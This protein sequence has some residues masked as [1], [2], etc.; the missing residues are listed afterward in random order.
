MGP[1]FLLLA[2]VALALAL[3]AGLN[4]LRWLQRPFPGF[5]LWGNLFV[6]AVGDTDWTGHRAGVPYQ[7]RLVAVDGA[8]VASATQVYRRAASVPVG[9]RIAYR[10]ATD[11]GERVVDIPTMRLSVPEY[12]WTFGNYL[13]LGTL[14]TLLGLVVSRIR[15]EAPAARALLA[16]AGTWGFYFI[17]AADIFGPGWFRPLCLLLQATAPVA[18]LHLALAFPVP[19]TVV[20]R[21]P[22]LLPVLYGCGVALGVVHNLVFHRWFGAMVAINQLT[23]LAMG[24]AG[25]VLIASLVH[26]FLYPPSA[27]VRQRTK[28]AVVGG[29]LAFV[30]PVF[31]V[32]FFSLT[33]VSFPINLVTLPLALFPLAIGYAIV[34]DDL[35]EVDAIIRRT[36]AWAILTGVIAAVYLGGVGTL[37]LVLTRPGGRVAQVMF[38]LAIVALVNPLRDRV[39]A[40]VDF[41]FARDRYDYRATVTEASQALATLLDLEA[42]VGRILRTITQGIHVDVGAVWLREAEHRYQL[43]AV[44]GARGRDGV[45]ALLDGTSALVARLERRPHEVV[46][47]GDG[48]RAPARELAQLGMTL[49]VPMALEHRLVGFLALGAK[50]SGR[51]YSGEDVQLVR[52]LANQGAVAAENAR[53][54]RA[55]VHANEEL[56]AAQS[57]LIEAE[58]LAAIGELSAA[59]AHGIRN[60]VAGIRAAAQVA[61]LDLPAD[62]PLRENLADIMLEA[63]KLEARIRGLLDFAKPFEPRPAPCQLD[64]LVAGALASLR[65]QIT[66]QAIVLE[67]AFDATLP[68]VPVDAVQIEQVVLALVS[69]A[70]EAMPEGGTLAVRGALTADGQRVRLEVADTGPGIPPDQL[71]RLFKLFFTTKPRGTGFGLAVAQKIVERHGGTIHAA[72]EPGKGSRFAIELP[73]APPA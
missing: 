61:S 32:S 38:L 18:V 47:D 62:H 20:R 52:T 30:V 40:A 37:E 39:Q 71:G 34:N 73:L 19:R 60:P 36:V 1:G 6:P 51:F 8:P 21:H 65:P 7:S 28:I 57:R 41:L 29:V 35:F 49:A 27:A 22:R 14:L 64:R 58:R 59:V 9:T 63:D 42:V 53:S 46:S 2:G 17:T 66:A 3:T 67:T 50:A 56:R 23:A 11:G 68:Q 25:A 45:P 10:F 48:E 4:S 54:Y 13:G 16:A 5:L 33:G 70:V 44:E 69:N 26:G 72:S 55:L 15:P 31:G 12:F 43:Q 24:L